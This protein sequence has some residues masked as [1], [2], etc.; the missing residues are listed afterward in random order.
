MLM[1][2]LVLYRFVC[3]AGLPILVMAIAAGELTWKKR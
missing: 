2:L 3:M 1:K